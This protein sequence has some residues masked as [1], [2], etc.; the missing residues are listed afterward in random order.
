MSVGKGRLAGHRFARIAALGILPALV[1]AACE[2]DTVLPGE[3]FGTRTALEATLPGEDGRAAAS[4]LVSTDAARAINLPS[5]TRL[6]DWP[7]RGYSVTNRLPHGTLSANPV[8]VWAA[9]IGTGNSR[10]NRIAADPVAGGGLVYTIDAGSQLQ[11][12]SLSGGAPAWITSLVPDFDRGANASGGG[13]ALSGNRLYATTP[14]GEVVALDAASGAVIWRQRLGT[15]LGA[16]TVSGGLVY[17]VGRNSEAWALEADDGRQRWRIPSSDVPSVLVGGSAPAVADGRAIFPF[18]SGELV[19]AM[20][21]TGITL[22]HSFV[23][24]G[25]LGTAYAGIND[26]TSDPV[27]VGG[28]I[29]AGNQSGRVVSMNARTGTRNW[30]ATEGA[31]SPVVVAGDAIFFVSDRNELIR[32]DA[33]DG[34]RVW[35][36]ELPLY[37]RDRPRRREAVFTHYGPVLAGGRLVVASG[38]GLIRLFSPE[39]GDLIGTLELRGGAASHPILVEDTLLV[40]SQDGRLHAYR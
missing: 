24:G 3:R 28:T 10:R 11:A 16:P 12:T 34:S 40:V 21:N 2:R 31:Y 18:P 6:A 15:V 22:W 36:T 20:P 33:S 29:Y 7:S 23:A 9:P 37:Q 19:A 8:E 1:L 14:F 30:T 25:R 4:S 5:P 35:G 39:S 17:V 38:D 13:L 32:L 26:I 27:I